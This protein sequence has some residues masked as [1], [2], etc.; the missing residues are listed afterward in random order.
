MNLLIR[1]AL[2]VVVMFLI[3][4]VYTGQN[5]E[6]VGVIARDSARK[7]AKFVGWTMVLVVVM[8][9]CFWLFVDAG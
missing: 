9:L 2:Y 1:L 3:M 7:T 5:H 6:D 8:E 4:L